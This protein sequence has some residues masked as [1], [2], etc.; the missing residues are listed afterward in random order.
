[1]NGN[2]KA[3]P[4]AAVL[5]VAACGDESGAAPVINV[6]DAGA[7]APVVDPAKFVTDITNPYL[8]LAVGSRW[9]LEGDE[10]Q[11]VEVVVTDQRR[12]IMGVSAVVVRDTEYEDGQVVEDTFDWF[13]QDVDGNVWY[14]GEDTA[15]Y[16][17]G[18]VVTRAGSWEAGLGGA[19][20]G[21]VMLAH[22]AAGA[23]YRQEY[24]AGEA[25]DMGE[26]LQVGADVTV[27]GK[28]YTDVVVTRDW[29]PLEP[30]VVEHKYYAPGVG[31]V[32]A[33][34]VRGGEGREELVEFSGA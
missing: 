7:Y 12:T 4:V 19:R 16:E 15:E 18:V 9:V 10:G 1:M 20:P 3:W 14:F 32:L 33:E 5:L 29:T 24:L 11:R 27:R 22:P 28:A 30:D 31:L 25:E 26:V 23:A 8:P 2:W 6:G 21:I 13:A 17:G 34:K